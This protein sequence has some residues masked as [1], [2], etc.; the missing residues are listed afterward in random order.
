MVLL[1]GLL[2]AQGGRAE[3]TLDNTSSANSPFR[4]LAWPHTVGAGTNQYL[5][6]SVVTRNSAPSF[7]SYR[8]AQLPS[9]GAR[10]NGTGPRVEMFGGPVTPGPGNVFVLLPA[11]F[12]QPVVG[13]AVSFTGVNLAAPTGVFASAIGN[14]NNPAVAGVAAG[15]GDVV[16]DVMGTLAAAGARTPVTPQQQLW[17]NQVGAY[18]G[19]GSG[20]GTDVAAAINMS[21]VLGAA[22]PWAI[23]AVAIK[24]A[25][26][27]RAAIGEVR[28]YRS[29][30]AGAVVE[31]QTL[32][33]RGTLG[34]DL[35]RLDPPTGEFRQLNRHLLPA[36]L[37]A[38]SGGRYRF[39]DLDAEPGQTYTYRLVELESSGDRLT[40]GPYTVKVA[41][42]RTAA[43]GDGDL[44]FAD[45]GG[46]GV[47]PDG[48]L[49]PQGSAERFVSDERPA[50]PEQQAR[51]QANKK[52]RRKAG[53]RKQ[54]R[55]GPLVKIAIREAGLYQVDAA[56]LAAA[57]GKSRAQVE[58]LV[59]RNRL[60]L[61]NRGKQVAT[62]PADGNDGIYFYGE[63]VVSQYT[64]ENVYWLGSGVGIAMKTRDAR[65]PAPVGG[66]SF[67]DTS[68]AEGNRYTLTNLFD[69]P[70]DDYWMWDFRF[71]DLR[72][73]MY[74]DVFT[75]SSPGVV[76]DAAEKATLVVR[77]HGGSDAEHAATVVLNGTEIGSTKFQGL[78]PHEARFPLD[79]GLLVDGDNSVEVY[80]R[81]SSDPDQPSVF[82]INDFTLE[83]SRR[84]SAAE[85][86][87]R[88]SSAGASVV[89]IAGFDS[90]DIRVFDI[91][92]PD[93]PVRLTRTTLD[94]SAGN[95]RV[96]L[97]T[98]RGERRYLALTPDAIRTPASVIADVK[99]DL[100]K[101][102]QRVDYLILTASDMVAAARTLADY[103]ASQGLRSLV[104]DIEDVYDEFSY[105]ITDADAIWTFLRYAYTKWRVAPRYVLLAGEGS[106]DY[107]NYLGFGDSVVPSL[108]SPTP[109]GLFP[110][111]NLYADVVGND[112]IPEMAIGR[113]PV[114]DADELLA[115]IAK[116]K[117]YEAASGPWEK[118]AMVAADA[119]DAGGDF[120]QESEIVSR[121]FPDDYLVEPVYLEDMPRDEAR[122]RVIDGINEGRAF[123][124]FFGHS[125]YL[126]LGNANLLSVSDVPRLQNAERLPVVT[127]FTCLAGQFGFPG[128]ESVGE[129][130]VIAPGG[131]AVAV[132]APSGLSLNARAR[133]LG[134][135]FYRA[136]FADGERV[137]GEI[138]LKAQAAYARDGADKYLLDIYN[139]IGDPA[140]RIK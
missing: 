19:N 126:G 40:Y 112:W 93:R 107:K 57:F 44:E 54:Q 128:Q 66:L 50:S 48:G 49:P 86:A 71:Q 64:E 51:V 106:I 125:G 25:V 119:P 46:S 63:P 131:G 81:A 20:R 15:A 70:D 97:R 59:A 113:L 30:V 99:S 88:L 114:I 68:R 105:G 39:L 82:Y 29:A 84:Y 3:I 41:A 108:L 139:L 34:F 4:I 135:G 24:P 122:A 69:D 104:V 134:Q 37:H 78:A 11:P 96:S 56:S 18:A 127:A 83:Y 123:F 45:D 14:S 92:N 120:T 36:R 133:I 52:A 74:Q 103:R 140:T 35:M 38:R 8:G 85:N 116:L 73:P 124:N 72:F 2:F 87:L 95:Y 21:W 100:R 43:D 111:D 117:A 137:L 6:V 91:D 138:V 101:R 132:W 67:R 65:R 7:V 17:A 26:F 13:G 110:S 76:A 80:G 61:T 53:K 1:A 98:P 75:V 33:E 102:S 47:L 118:Q 31:W 55:K 89:S 22:Q 9:I 77:L 27:T 58:R 79:P 129:A 94:G 10:G 23:G 32:S 136:T 42:T 16:V 130:L 90:T 28:A 115:V 109:Q 60:A 121:L 12:F 5:V 62:M